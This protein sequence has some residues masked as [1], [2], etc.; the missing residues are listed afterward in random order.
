MRHARVVIC[1]LALV[2]VTAACGPRPSPPPPS[3]PPAVA[4]SINQAFGPF[5]QTVVN[6]AFRV[7]RCESGWVATAGA[8]SYYQGLFQLGRHIVAINNYGG[9]FLDPWQNAQAARDL[10]YSRGRSWSAW[11][12]RP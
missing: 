5:G 7:A 10:Y 11:T 9:N 4:M 2:A 3:I 6:Q 12:C 8:G 1:V